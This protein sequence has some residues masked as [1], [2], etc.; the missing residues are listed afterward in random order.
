MDLEIKKFADIDLQDGFFDSLRDSYPE[1]DQW[2]TKKARVGESAYVFYQENGL[3]NDFLYL[4][5][6]GGEISDVEPALPAKKRLK[7]GTFK[8]LS[9][10][11]RRGERFMK[12]IMDRAIVDD[13]D[14]IYVTIFPTNEL[15]YLI[16][17][18][19]TFGFVHLADKDHGGK[20]KEWVL[21]KDMRKMQD[22]VVKDYPFVKSVGTNKRL[23]SIHPTYH[24]KLFPDSILKNESYDLVQDITPTNGI[25]KIYICWMKDAATLRRGDN[26]VIY[27]MGDGKGPAYYR[28][29][30]TSLCTVTEVK[31]YGD[32]DSLESF[33]KYTQYSVFSEV[34]RRNWYHFKS[35]FIVI[36]MLYNVAFTKRVIRK[37][38][39]EKVGISSDAYWGFCPLTDEQYK[40][41]L[42]LGGA[43]GRYFVD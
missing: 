22:D 9:R 17:S 3:V 16:K 20:G 10:G 18:F 41:I 29:V 8:L 6:E 1:F 25:Y 34:E 27:R 32:F 26:V 36:K 35:S 11:T 30:A 39:L 2:F 38:L 5:N 15:K 24:T 12:K 19:E 4:K 14:E 42:E 40:K 37:D 13:V 31:Q 7:V 23:L 28:A 21:V 33:L 43:D